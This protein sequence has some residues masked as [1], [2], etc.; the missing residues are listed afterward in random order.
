V[1]AVVVI[2]SANSSNTLA[3]VKVARQAGCPLVQR[4]DSADELDLG[5]LDGVR[6]VG[7]TA[8]A[9][10]PEEMV[11]AVIRRLDPSQGV[12]LLEV[13]DEDEYFPPPRALRQ[14]A[15][16]MGPNPVSNRLLRA[17]STTTA[18]GPVPAQKK[19]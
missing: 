19:G 17:P 10:A 9:S 14:L 13:T 15:K 2:G 7:V 11:E 16:A 4:V 5:R 3:L 1:D 18:P 8:G 12:E 6:L